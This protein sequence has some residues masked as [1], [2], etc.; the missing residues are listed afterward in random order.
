MVRTAL[1]NNFDLL[2]KWS[3]KSLTWFQLIDFAFLDGI[4]NQGVCHLVVAS[5]DIEEK[6][7]TNIVKVTK[8]SLQ[9]LL[10]LFYHLALLSKL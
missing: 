1:V 4:H 3:P 7:R 6:K 9:L 2:A 8:L 5:M 10:L